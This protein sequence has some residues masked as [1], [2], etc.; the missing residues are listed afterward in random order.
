MAG[1]SSN[2]RARVARVLHRKLSAVRHRSA[3][4]VDDDFQRSPNDS[5]P[6]HGT[7]DNDP[8]PGDATA[9]HD[10]GPSRAE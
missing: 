6:D 3:A 4:D 2:D 1:W 5:H 7:C 10:S 9:E 8:D